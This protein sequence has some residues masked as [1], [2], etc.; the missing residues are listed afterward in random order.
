M[1]TSTKTAQ[2]LTARQ[3]LK[4]LTWTVLFGPVVGFLASPLALMF[5]FD[6]DPVPERTALWVLLPVATISA[7]PFAR[8]WLRSEHTHFPLAVLNG[9]VL[10][11]FWSIIAVWLVGI[12]QGF[13]PAPEF[14]P[15]YLVFGGVPFGMGGGAVFWISAMNIGHR[16]PEG[17]GA[18]SRWSIVRKVASTVAIAW[19]IELILGSPV[20]ALVV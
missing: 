2:H 10:G 12:L 18:L 19:S 14:L 15:S 8:L 17:G 4:A 9:A 20:I 6:P 11:A 7:F 3:T 13:S 5:L 1:Q 16:S